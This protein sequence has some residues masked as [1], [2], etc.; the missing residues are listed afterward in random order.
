M[1]FELFVIILVILL[2]IWVHQRRKKNLQ[3]TKFALHQ[4]EDE[5][6]FVEYRLTGKRKKVM[7]MLEE[8]P[9]VT[10]IEQ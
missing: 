1:L 6:T 2:I 7:I 9:S 4:E 10:E 8:P 5:E 3:H